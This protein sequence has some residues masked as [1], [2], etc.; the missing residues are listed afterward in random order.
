VELYKEDWERVASHVGKS[1]AACMAR[2][3]RLPIEDPFIDDLLEWTETLERSQQQQQQQ[4]IPP[5]PF[6]DE[7]NPLM[8]TLGALSTI[9]GPKVAA[10]AAQASLQALAEQ[11]LTAGA[12]LDPQVRL[13]AVS[14]AAAN[15][16]LGVEDG[17]NGIES[18]AADQQQQEQQP[19]DPSQ[20]IDKQLMMSAVAAGLAAAATR[21]KLLA[22]AEER[23]IQ[24]LM[25]GLVHDAAKRV[26]AKLNLLSQLMDPQVRGRRVY[27][28]WSIGTVSSALLDSKH[29]V[30]SR[31]KCLMCRAMCW[32][33]AINKYVKRGYASTATMPTK[34]I[35]QTAGT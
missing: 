35:L 12:V 14:A 13:A 11:D 31:A 22:M 16:Q 1:Q 19:A 21:A 4:K 25:V 33:Q 2:F 20:P 29:C 30:D 32:L 28:C 18:Q 9:L 7:P 5:L 34:H 17:M 10:A 15:G 3:A 6:L 26:D 27:C 23:E 24:R 8:A